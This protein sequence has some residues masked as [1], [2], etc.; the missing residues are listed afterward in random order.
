MLSLDNR[1]NNLGVSLQPEVD[2]SETLG[3][4]GFLWR[5][6]ILLGLIY[7]GPFL[8]P[9][10]KSGFAQRGHVDLAPGRLVRMVDSG[11]YTAAWAAVDF[12]FNVWANG[13]TVQASTINDK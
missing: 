4:P 11:L 12:V 3:I 1:S 13:S 5:L 7:S 2:T 9:V 8:W 10:R 6:A